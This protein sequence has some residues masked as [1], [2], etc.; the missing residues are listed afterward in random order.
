MRR[1]LFI[2]AVFCTT[3]LWMVV[4]KPLFLLFYHAQAA[5]SSFGEW[6]GVMWHGLT[7]DSTVAGYVTA[8]PVL[9]V[10]F[11]LWIPLSRRVWRIILTVYFALISLFAATI[12]AVDL[13]LY[14]YWGFR[15]DGSVLIYLS[16]PKEAMAS[17]SWGET[18]RQV[19]ILLL[20]GGAMMW[21]YLGVLRLFRNDPLPLLRR[22]G[23]S[24]C[25]LFIAGLTFLAIRGGVTVATANVSKVYFSA[26]MF[27]NHAATNPIFSFLSSVG[28]NKDYA[29][30]YPFFDEERRAA[31][32]DEIRGNRP[33]ADEGTPQL[34][35]T[36]RPNVVLIILESFS[37]TIMD[38]TVDGEPVMPWMNRLKEEGI[39]F[40]NFYANSFRTDRGEVAI[41]SG[42]PAQTSMSIMKLPRKSATL[43]SMARSLQREGYR[44]LF[45][46]GGDLNFT[47]QSSFMYATGWERLIWQKDLQ[48]DAPT[49][50]WGYADDVMIP[51]FGDEVER[52]DREGQ[53]FLAGLLTL[54]SHE[55]FEVPYS[56]FE[57]KLLNSMAF[58]DEQVGLLIERLKASPAWDNL[59]V[60]L[61]ADHAYMYPYN[62]AYNASLRHRIPMIWTG[63]AVRE[64]MK[65]E[66]FAS[67]IDLCATLLAQLGLS[68]EEFDFSKN[69]FGATPPHKFGYWCFS[70][71]FGVIDAEGETIYDHA[72]GRV[73]SGDPDSERLEWGKALLQTTYEDIDRR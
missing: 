47:N 32:F 15:L 9:I 7:L 1:F 29:S 33:G 73:V 42:Y 17:L 57:D 11:S 43:P 39:W 56:K 67:Q 20:Y 24:L 13:G 22:I 8:F 66:T 30:A 12:F 19:A 52:L 51:L 58:A 61:V 31:L 72:T 46:Y 70:D 64:P 59:L 5:Q 34:L 65:V 45:M 27:L 63:G 16:D 23:A 68:H 49:S 4:Q 2:L 54:S 62:V 36:S 28:S 50:K 3:V 48:L 10:L 14:G 21:S 41:L 6:L 60:V 25:T 40:E 71:G 37:R 44:T 69:I 18:L 26:N 35:T 55:P 53:P 38:E